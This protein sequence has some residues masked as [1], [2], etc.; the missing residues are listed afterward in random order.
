ML[1]ANLNKWLITQ[2][3]FMFNPAPGVETQGRLC[4]IK[5]ALV[6]QIPTQAL[7][8]ILQ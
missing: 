7:A 4:G 3:T 8:E 5:K 6:D 2:A 1:L